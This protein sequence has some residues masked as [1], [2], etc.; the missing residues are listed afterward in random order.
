MNKLIDFT[1]LGGYPLAQED[2]DWLQSS[3]RTAFGELAKLIGDMTIIS[4]MVEAGGN[5]T[6]GWISINGELLPFIGGAIGTGECLIEETKQSLTFQDAQIQDV[7]ITRV[8]RFGSPGTFQYSDL[9]R[10]GTLKEVWQ[11]LDVKQ[12]VCDAAYMAANFD[13]TGKGTNKRTGWAICNGQNGTADLR[14]RF[15]VGYSNA[16][17]D[18]DLQDTGGLKEVT[19][20]TNQIPAHSHRV[21]NGSGG[22]NTNSLTEGSA[23]IAGMDTNSGYIGGT[24]WVENTGGGLAHQ[25]LPPYYTVLFIQKL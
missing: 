23:G 16:D 21:R 4:G 7:L 25:N 22:S 11:P 9:V 2:L 14:G 10:V 8:A 17:G 3:Y 20:T 12:I 24:P 5:V 15:L 6:N 1:K 18:Y 13:G 19:L